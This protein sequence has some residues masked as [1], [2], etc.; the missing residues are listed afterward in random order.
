LN[1]AAILAA[2]PTITLNPDHGRVSARLMRRTAG[3]YA[4][5]CAIGI[6]PTLLGA[7]PAWQAFGWGLWLPGGAFLAAGGWGWVAFLAAL[8]VFGLAV[9]LWFVMGNLIA[10]P[11]AW[12][13]AAVLG[14]L[15]VRGPSPPYVL[16]LTPTLVSALIVW[17]IIAARGRQ[18]VEHVTRDRR[19]AYL[20]QAIAATAT[21]AVMA[22]STAARELDP[23]MLAGLRYIYDRALQPIDEF[24]GFDIIDQFRESALRYQLNY[25]GYA[26]A[27]AQC[28]YVPNFRGYLQHAQRNTIDKF[29][30]RRVWSYWRIENALGNLRFDADPIGRDNIM[31]GGFYNANLALYAAG[32]GDARYAAPGALKFRL[33]DRTVFEHDAH[34][35][36]AAARANYAASPFCLYPCEPSFAFSYC[37]LLALTGIQVNDR[38]FGTDHAHSIVPEFRRHFENEFLDADGSIIAG[39]VTRTGMRFHFFDATFTRAA[40]CYLANPHFPDIAERTWAMLREERVRFD[41]AGELDLDLSFMDNLDIGNYR[42]TNAGMYVE[43][44][45]AGR[46]H[47]DDEV[48]D[49]ALRGLDRLHGRLHSDG[50]LRY[51]GLSNFNNA[52]VV[53]GRMM[54]RHDWRNLVLDGPPAEAL[55][56]PVLA[57]VK[58]P[59]VQVAR[60]RSDGN[61]LHLVLYPGEAAHREPSTLRLEQLRPRALY[62]VTGA[63][64]T[65]LTAD[66][67]GTAILPVALD[68]RTS[69]YLA[70]A[71]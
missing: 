49:A 4:L 14:A 15:T 44:L 54:R 18:R 30:D 45:L 43:L 66:D 8:A 16:L 20:P 28:H 12:L 68:G 23:D 56:G 31:L 55:R 11:V 34:T 46:E 21:R 1:A 71:H 52:H 13:A 39:R 61:D 40:Y 51:G 36:T 6:L 24:Q 38:V 67:R 17:R 3:V 33:N 22:P 48:A 32:T 9:M 47:G 58:F 60:A 7:S 29:L 41:A 65:Q 10:I 64:T 2:G 26:L 62:N 5:V 27:M 70:P 50:S 42:R 63:T 25:M 59:D 53:M 57:D 35:V 19:N 37:N 69:L